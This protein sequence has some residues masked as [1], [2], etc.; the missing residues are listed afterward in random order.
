MSKWFKSVFGRGDA[1][2]HHGTSSPSSSSWHSDAEQL[3]LRISDRPLHFLAKY[4][5]RQFQV[6][7][8]GFETV[9]GFVDFS[10][11]NVVRFL[12]Q[13]CVAALHELTSKAV[14]PIGT[15]GGHTVF[16]FMDADGGS[17][18][19]DMELSLFAPLSATDDDFV[20]LL[21]GG[22]NCRVD[23]FILDESGRPTG[24][25]IREANESDFW[26]ISS[27]PHVSQFLPSRS[28]SPCRRPPTWRPMMKSAEELLAEGADPTSVLVTC[29][30]FTSAPSGQSFFVSHCENSLYVRERAGFRV[31]PPPPGVQVG[32]RPGECVAFTPPSHWS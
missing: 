30:G 23:S 11:E 6:P 8:D 31:S 27:F 24:E 16:L 9:L 14:C 26:S 25:V 3:G 5:G 32:L 13:P 29:G 17:F 21:C 12:D 2:S 1:P 15:T 4:R 20:Q 10:P 28:L 22:Q 7:I 19:L 18:A